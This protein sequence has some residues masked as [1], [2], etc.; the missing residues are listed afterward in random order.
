MTNA[1]PSFAD[2]YDQMILAPAMRALYNETGFYNVGYWA[3]APATLGQACQALVAQ[4]LQLVRPDARPATI[5][6]V[7][8]GLGATTALLVQAYPAATVT[9]INLSARQ[10]AYA[11][12]QVPGSLFRVMDAARM[13]FPPDS[14]DLLVSVEAAFH[15]NTR[16]DFLLEA[17]R[18]LR[19]GGQLIFSDLLLRTTDWVGNWSVPEANWLPDVTTYTRMLDRL[20]FANQ[21]LMDVTAATWNGFCHHLYQQPGF[22]QLATG[23]EASAIA[24]LL[25]VLTK[26]A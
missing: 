1:V 22:Q 21:Y 15:F 20:P 4:H 18:V 23:L 5:L 19:P 24:Y 3:D 25:V 8:C 11:R 13:D 16:R 6:D 10:V 26:T 2:Q 14:F 17:H 7:G 9:G 12:Q